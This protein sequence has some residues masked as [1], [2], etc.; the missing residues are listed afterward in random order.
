MNTKPLVAVLMS[1][2]NGERCLVEQIESI[3]NQ[4]DVAVRLVIRDDGSKDNTVSIAR[5]YTDDIIVGNN[6]GYRYSFLE[7]IKNTPTAD[8]Y[9]LADQDDIWL[10]QK[11]KWAIESFPNEFNNHPV[12]YASSRFNYV[13]GKSEEPNELHGYK[14]TPFN[15]FDNGYHLQGCTMV[16]NSELRRYVEEFTPLNLITSHDVWLHQLCKAIGGQIIYD[17]RQSLLYRIEN[18]TIGVPTHRTLKRIESLFKQDNGESDIENLSSNLYNG[19]ATYMT[20]ENQKI[21]QDLMNYRSHLMKVLF[22]PVYYKGRLSIKLFRFAS[23]L[24]KKA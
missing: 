9:A 16:F 13:N 11:L 10:P 6:L 8:F 1:T 20:I 21:C 3:L 23:F 2:Y 17:D 22:N 7:L 5:K 24:F 14:P 18:N 15:C 12:L 19:Y 4:E